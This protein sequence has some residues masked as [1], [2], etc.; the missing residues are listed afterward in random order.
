MDKI[1]FQNKE[2]KV[3]EIELLEFGCVLISTT[4]LNDALINNG[5]DYVSKE[6]Q[7]I[8]ELLY[9]FVEEDEIELNEQDLVMLVTLQAI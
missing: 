4:S 1:Q 9:F 2:Y 6:A 3:R 5:G 8:D 7:S